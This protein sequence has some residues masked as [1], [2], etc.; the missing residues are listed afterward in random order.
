MHLNSFG[1][2]PQLGFQY[3]HL[4]EGSFQETGA[5]GQD[6]SGAAHG[7][8]SARPF[9][10][11]ILDR[12]YHTDGGTLIAPEL[13]A[14]YSYELASTARRVN[15]TTATG[16][17]FLVNGISPSRSQP[18]VGAGIT[19]AAPPKLDMFLRYDYAPRSG[20]ETSTTVSAGLRYKF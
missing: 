11:A 3:T 1:L 16:S 18:T 17:A 2:T 13:H 20:N 14:G 19:V 8:D 5:N 4:E 9:V 12:P 7:T 6:L 15:T 10:A